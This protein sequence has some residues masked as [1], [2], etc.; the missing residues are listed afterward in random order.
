MAAAVAMHR[1]TVQHQYVHLMMANWKKHVVYVHL[2]TIKRRELHTDGNAH[3]TSDHGSH[4]LT[5]LLVLHEPFV[6]NGDLL[7]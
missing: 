6:K 7:G 3:Q 1:P 2:C 5:I 4:C